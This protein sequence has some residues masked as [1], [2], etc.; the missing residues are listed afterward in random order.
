M[1]EI[2]ENELNEVAG[3]GV[4]GPDGRQYWLVHVVNYG[5]TLTGIGARY[6]VNYLW[7]AQLNGI[8]NPDLIRVG[9]KIYIPFPGR[10]Y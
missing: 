2:N 6:G 8:A 5:D 4:T 3:G 7:L 9:Q 1:A 10:V